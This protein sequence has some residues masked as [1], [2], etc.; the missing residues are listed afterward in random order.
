MKKKVLLSLDEHVDAKLVEL[1]RDSNKS[2]FIEKLI[3]GY[4]LL[5]K[6]DSHYP[7]VTYNVDNVASILEG[8]PH[9]KDAQHAVNYVVI[10]LAHK[11]EQNLG[12]PHASSMN[13]AMT[14]FRNKDG[15]TDNQGVWHDGV[16]E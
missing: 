12:T 13:P 16:E 8:F 9:L 11:A 1:S 2:A 5:D 14:K 15:Y 10:A 7:R 3:S 6:I 4:T